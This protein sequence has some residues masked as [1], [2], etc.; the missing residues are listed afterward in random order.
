MKIL[1]THKRHLSAEK[2]LALILMFFKK[3]V[4]KKILCVIFGITPSVCSLYLEFSLEIL[5]GLF[6]DNL[7]PFA[8]I[9]LP[10]V[11]Q[12]AELARIVERYEPLVKNCI[13]FL[14]GCN[15]V[16]ESMSDPNEQ[17]CFYNGWHSSVWASNLFFVL[18]TGEIAYAALNYPGS[19]H[20]AR[21]AFSSKMH[22]II[23]NLP[24]PYVIL[25]DTAFLSQEYTGKIIRVLKENEVR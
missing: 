11:E 12:L 24:V 20:D 5:F 13:G 2:S 17:N 14:D 16:T 19:W 1:L 22:E 15:M 21:I 23:L 18:P 8:E 4:N 10:T 9:F 7:V 6:S 3:H 25:A